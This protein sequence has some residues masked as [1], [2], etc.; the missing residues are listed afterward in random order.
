MF[1]SLNRDIRPA[2]IM[3]SKNVVV[4]LESDVRNASAAESV[5]LDK[6][7]SKPTFES[8]SLV[9]ELSYCSARTYESATLV[10][11]LALN[12]LRNKRIVQVSMPVK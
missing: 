12:Y 10:S 1:A 3:L 4:K 6:L 5:I 9:I 7:R 11:F 8:C 2:N